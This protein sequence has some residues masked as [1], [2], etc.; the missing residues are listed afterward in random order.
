MTGH[1]FA[2]LLV[3]VKPSGT[4]FLFRRNSKTVPDTVRKIR[5]Y[6]TSHGV[7][8]LTLEMLRTVV[9][10]LALSSVRKVIPILEIR[11]SISLLAKKV[12]DALEEAKLIDRRLHIYRI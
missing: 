3:T 2:S 5:S 1:S 11:A 4:L 6:W 10:E 7:T 12:Y 9:A 8:E